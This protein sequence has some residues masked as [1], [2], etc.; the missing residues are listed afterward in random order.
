[1]FTA[2]FCFSGAC[3]VFAA[4]RARQLVG[5]ELRVQFGGGELTLRH[6]PDGQIEMTGPAVAVYEGEINVES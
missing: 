1:M 4:L 6:R 5:A 3:A 2:F